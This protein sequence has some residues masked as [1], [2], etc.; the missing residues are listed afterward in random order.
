[1][2]E[3]GREGRGQRGRGAS[4]PS[5][6]LPRSS[7]VGGP[8]L[9][10][11][12]EAALPAA[13]G[14][15]HGGPPRTVL[16]PL[17]AQACVPSLPLGHTASDPKTGAGRLPKGECPATAGLSWEAPPTA[18]LSA[19]RASR[20]QP[21]LPLSL[22]T[23]RLRPSAQTGTGSHGPTLSEAPQQKWGLV[24]G[25]APRGMGVLRGRPGSG[26]GSGAVDASGSSFPGKGPRHT[27]WRAVWLLPSK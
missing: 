8:G 20:S 17:P 16:P 11:L 18:T 5:S 12:E 21:L 7:G 14:D 2:R 24:L 10:L 4:L 19:H 9:L 3:R 25:E 27:W 13:V 6:F 22:Q 26:L 1:M 15:R 23:C